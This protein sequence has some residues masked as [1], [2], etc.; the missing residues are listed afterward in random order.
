VTATRPPAA[1]PARTGQDRQYQRGDPEQDASRP[2]GHLTSGGRW[3]EPSRAHLPGLTSGNAPVGRTAVFARC[4]DSGYLRAVS[5]PNATPLDAL[6]TS[7]ARHLRGRNLS[8]KTIE[9]CLGA[10]RTLTGWLVEDTDVPSWDQVRKARLETWLGELLETRSAGHAE[11]IP[12]NPMITMSPP[13]VEEA[14]P[15]AVG[16]APH[17][18]VRELQG[19]GLRRPPRPCD[20]PA[21]RRDRYPA[22]RDG[23]L[24]LRRGRPGPHDV[25]L[26]TRLARVTGKGRREGL[27]RFDAGTSVAIDRWLRSRA[28]SKW[29]TGPNCGWPRRTAGHSPGRHLPNGRAPRGA[30][31]DRPEHLRSRVDPATIP[32][33]SH[34]PHPLVPYCQ[35]VHVREYD[36][37]YVE[38]FAPGAFADIA[39][40][41]EVELTALHP[42]SGAELPIGLTLTLTDSPTGLDGEWR[43]NNELRRRGPH[44]GQGYGAALPIG[45]GSQTAA[46]A[47]TP[48]HG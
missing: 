11:E 20:P 25:D 6:V 38:D 30:G 32:E 45:W 37:A 19:Q 39:R 28:T 29:A 5:T 43:I 10:S 26:D 48:S 8:P 13:K 9:I 17:G 7:F 4:L 35:P 23:R 47:G 34:D 36:K 18:A 15:G 16:R 2:G 24:A 27:V 33:S 22:R 1:G 44:P 21:V 3:F 12:A 41:A 46:T 14:R 31:R 42:R 40:A